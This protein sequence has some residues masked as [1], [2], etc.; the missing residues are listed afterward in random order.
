MTLSQTAAKLK[1]VQ[2]KAKKTQA[3]AVPS[4]FREFYMSLYPDYTLGHLMPMYQAIT[5]PSLTR[6]CV[7]IPAQSGKS[8]IILSYLAYL[9]LT[10][11]KQHIYATYNLRQASIVAQRVCDRILEVYGISMGSSQTHWKR[12]SAEVIFTSI[13]G[14]GTGNPASGLYI[15][16]DY[17]SSREDA[18]SPTE[19]SKVLAW[20]GSS[21]LTRVHK[22]GRVICIATRWHNQ[23][24]SSSLIASGYTYI[25][26]PAITPDG[27]SY[28]EAGKPLTML[29]KIRS[30]VGDYIW[31]SMYMGSPIGM[32]S[33]LFKTITV[34]SVPDQIPDSIVM[35][36]DTAYGGSD[37]CSY[38]V[39][40]TYGSKSYVVSSWSGKMGIDIWADKVKQVWLKYNKPTIYTTGSGQ[41]GTV[42]DLL[43]QKYCIPIIY[44]KTTVSKAIRALDTA[45]RVNRGDILLGY[46]NDALYVQM[47]SFT[48]KPGGRDDMIDALVN[49]AQ[50]G[51]PYKRGRSDKRVQGPG[52]IRSRW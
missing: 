11:D 8:T 28:W 51:Q 41:E 38:V 25:N 35:G 32:E 2:Q 10:T 39:I 34:T 12:G 14:T 48:G 22:T 27:H 24:L 7:S 30:E 29:E 6:V 43:S 36:I 17:C 16:D 31:Y 3:P 45:A 4:S 44:N 20:Y 18:E 52:I 23:D 33:G 9:Y 40:S 1:R 13:G 47:M 26:I 50:L 21:C 42:Y 49:A 19:R 46:G 37:M 5:D 15:I